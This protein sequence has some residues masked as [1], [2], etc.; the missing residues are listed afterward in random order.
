MAAENGT[1]MSTLMEV[2]MFGTL[3]V[4]DPTQKK[5]KTKSELDAMIENSIN[6]NAVKLK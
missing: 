5:V 4:T 3:D 2:G 1:E 6:E